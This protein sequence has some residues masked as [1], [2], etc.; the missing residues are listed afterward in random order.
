METKKIKIKTTNEMKN[1]LKDLLPK[2][3]S[4]NEVLNEVV[5]LIVSGE[6]LPFE[7]IGMDNYDV[8]MID[9]DFTEMIELRVPIELLEE[10][11]NLLTEYG[12][13]RYEVFNKLILNR[14]SSEDHKSE[15]GHYPETR[16]KKWKEFLQQSV[17]EDMSIRELAKDFFYRRAS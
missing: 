3:K 7:A 2:D 5:R 15:H 11:D 1:K 9:T 6:A 17:N 8:K 12:Y 16:W 14:I 10:F 4:L 13:T